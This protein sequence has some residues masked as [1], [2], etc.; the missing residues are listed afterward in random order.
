M[1]ST[2]EVALSMGAR[3]KKAGPEYIG[4]CP[5]CGGT[6]RFSIN[7]RKDLYNC[8]HCGGGDAIELVRRATGMSYPAALEQVDDP[9][10]HASTSK[11][12]APLLGSPH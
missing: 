4:P 2:L 11:P 6:D 3:L 10:R 1:K 12:I 9:R 7:V 5:M 8:R